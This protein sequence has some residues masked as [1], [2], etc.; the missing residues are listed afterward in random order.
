MRRVMRK[1]MAFCTK[2]RFP[3]PT[4]FSAKTRESKIINIKFFTSHISALN[5]V[6]MK[7]FFEHTYTCVCVFHLN[8]W[9]NSKTKCENFIN[10]KLWHPAEEFCGAKFWNFTYNFDKTH[11]LGSDSGRLFMYS[12]EI[13]LIFHFFS[14]H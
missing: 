9:I 14:F 7:I 10:R 1:I 3:S 5:F 4:I 13:S 2:C 8:S 12:I 11:K 6:F